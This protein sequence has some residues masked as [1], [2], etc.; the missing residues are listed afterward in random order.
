MKLVELYRINLLEDR[1]KP[2]LKPLNELVVNFKNSNKY[3]AIMVKMKFGRRT[4]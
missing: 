2:I 3:N 4:V 1:F